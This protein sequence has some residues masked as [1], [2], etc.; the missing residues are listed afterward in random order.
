MAESDEFILYDDMQYTKRD[1]RNRNKIK[2]PQG[3]KWLTIPVEVSGKFFQ[4]ICETK[5]SEKDWYRSHWDTL[6]FAYAKAPHFADVKDFME[7]LY[8]TATSEYLSEINYHFLKGIADFLGI[9][10]RITFS[11]SYQYDGDKTERLVQLCK[12]V[13]AT[14]YFT[15]PAAKEYMD[16]NLFAAENIKVHY[17]DYGGYSEY[18]QLYPPFE[19]FV[20]VVDLLFSEGAGA[21]NYLKSLKPNG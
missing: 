10:A 21:K 16:E 20:S 5:I 13:N 2:T 18:E 8:M 14:D 15:G 17:F 11:S 6:R 7:N 1:W 19:H 12:L 4:K 3:I 9:H